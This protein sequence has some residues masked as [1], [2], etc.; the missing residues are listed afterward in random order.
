MLT[1]LTNTATLFAE[2]NVRNYKFRVYLKAAG[3]ID[4]PFTCRTP[5]EGIAALKAQYGCDVVWLS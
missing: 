4:V 2:K 3:F 1:G 5:G